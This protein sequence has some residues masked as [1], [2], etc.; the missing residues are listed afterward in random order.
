MYSYD[1]HTACQ[2]QNKAPALPVAVADEPLVDVRSVRTHPHHPVLPLC[3]KLTFLI[4]KLFTLLFTGNPFWIRN[5]VA[6]H[7]FLSLGFVEKLQGNPDKKALSLGFIEKFQD[8]PGKK[9]YL[10]VLSK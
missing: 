8:N 6:T 5:S 2:S 10:Y 9:N 4:P 1:N 7:Y 3:Y